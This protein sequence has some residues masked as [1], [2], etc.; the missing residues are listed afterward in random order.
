MEANQFAY[1][2]VYNDI[3]DKIRDGKFP[4]ASLLPPES[5]LCGIYGVSRTTVRNAVQL[6]ES[7]GYVKARQGYGT[8]VL[9]FRTTQKLNYIS[10]F[11][12]TLEAKGFSVST[13]SMH[14]DTI[15]PD[16][17]LAQELKVSE[18][19]DVVRVQR[20][21]LANKKPIAYITDYIIAHL[22]AGIEKDVGKFVS[23]YRHIEKNYGVTI[24]S[25]VDT[26]KAQTAD[27]MLA[28]ILGVSAGS[29]ILVNHRVVCSHGVPILVNDVL[30]DGSRMEYSVAVEGRIE[31]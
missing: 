2:G 25:A 13:K 15:K 17:L 5:A 22:V 24:T 1:V 9:D 29:P 23:L 30:I 18:K 14:I 7:E 10:S 20:L 28:E 3:R 8:E 31:H 19:T 11:T 21:Q 4:I 12:R 26:I 16:E 27:F 6:L